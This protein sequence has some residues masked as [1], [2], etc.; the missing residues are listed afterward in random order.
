MFLSCVYCIRLERVGQEKSLGS[1]NVLI[2]GVRCPAGITEV[3]EAHLNSVGG[4]SALIALVADG[5]SVV[6]HM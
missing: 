1:P 2:P 3:E 5:I 6:V 4:E